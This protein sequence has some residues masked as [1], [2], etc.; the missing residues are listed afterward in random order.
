MKS[1][2]SNVKTIRTASPSSSQDAKK[3]APKQDAQTNNANRSG[4]KPL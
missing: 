3:Q 2:T 4:R 1:V